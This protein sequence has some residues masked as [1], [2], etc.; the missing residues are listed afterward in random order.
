MWSASEPSLLFL[1]LRQHQRHHVAFAAGILKEENSTGGE[2]EKAVKSLIAHAA[3]LDEEGKKDVRE[4]VL[5][6]L[7]DQRIAVR[8]AAIDSL[9]RLGLTKDLKEEDM[10]AGVIEAVSDC[11]VESVSADVIE[12]GVVDKQWC[13]RTAAIDALAQLPTK[14]NGVAMKKAA[15][16]LSR[17]LAKFPFRRMNPLETIQVIETLGRLFEKD[18]VAVDSWEV[19]HIAIIAVSNC[20]GDAYNLV[21]YEAMQALEK[22]GDKHRA[23][24]IAA[25]SARIDFAKTISRLEKTKCRYVVWKNGYCDLE[26]PVTILHERVGLPLGL[27]FNLLLDRRNTT[28]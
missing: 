20:L 5:V 25:V 24:V 7:K 22:F 2:C 18:S 26:V 12:A 6:R 21:R 15:L 8:L 27:I 4:A 13:V 3:L 9:A 28:C 16:A 23:E 1:Q 17:H 19:G 11:L 10:L 14:P